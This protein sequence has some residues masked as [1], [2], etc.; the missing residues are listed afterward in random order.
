MGPDA[1][2]SSPR[3]IRPRPSFLPGVSFSLF[4]FNHPID[5]PLRHMEHLGDLGH[6]PFQPPHEETDPRVP[7]PLIHEE[8]MTE[9]AL[10]SLDFGFDRRRRVSC[11][12]PL[13]STAVVASPD[14][15]N[16]L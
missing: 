1:S 5:A 8:P 11:F 6:G 13:R 9:I 16:R 10:K 4:P 7:E 3:W 2:G 12:G 15:Q 14:S